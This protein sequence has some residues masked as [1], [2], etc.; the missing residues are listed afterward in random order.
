[1]QVDRHDIQWTEGVMLVQTL[2]DSLCWLVGGHCLSDSQLKKPAVLT[3]TN[4]LI[5]MGVFNSQLI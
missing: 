2:S 1:M 4:Q 3:T 5:Q